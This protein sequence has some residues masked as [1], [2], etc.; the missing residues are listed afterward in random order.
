[1]VPCDAM[2]LTFY[3]PACFAEHPGALPATCPSCGTDTE[4]WTAEHSYTERLINAL[5]HP[6]SEPRMSSIISLGQ[7]AP[8]EAALPLAQCLL[9]HP[10]DTWQGMEILRSLDRIADG[11]EKREALIRLRAHP[12]RIISEEVA[13]RLL[14]YDDKG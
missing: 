7:Q 14:H 1:M 3:C 12:S 2:S 4:R 10:V 6:S 13:Q 8:P 5:R 11:P 9:D